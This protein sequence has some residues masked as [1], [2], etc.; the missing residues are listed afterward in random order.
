MLIKW[1]LAIWGNELGLETCY[2]PNIFSRMTE[3]GHVSELYHIYF[4]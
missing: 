4:S 3:P 2:I 1:G